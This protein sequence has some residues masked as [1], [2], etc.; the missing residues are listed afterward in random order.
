MEVLLVVYNIAPSTNDRF[1]PESVMVDQPFQ[2]TRTET[3][4]SES[5][6]VFCDIISRVPDQHH[7]SRVRAPFQSSAHFTLFPS[8]PPCQKES[9]VQARVQLACQRGE[10]LLIHSRPERSPRQKR[11]RRHKPTPLSSGCSPK[12]AMWSKIHSPGNR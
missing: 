1:I 7:R 3:C 4:Q 10:G 6:R 5:D 11:R 8:F 12:C 9:T 2:L